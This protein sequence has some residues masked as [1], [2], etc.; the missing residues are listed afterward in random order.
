[1]NKNRRIQRNNTLMPPPP[2]LLEL[3][4]GTG[5]IGRAFRGLGWRV[6]SVDLDPLAGATIT[7]DISQLQAADLPRTPDVIWASPPCT[8]YSLAGCRSKRTTQELEESDQLVRKTLQLVEELGNPPCFI[9]NPFSG[10]LKRRGLLDHL[11]MQIV[12]YC[13]YSFPYRKR[14]AIWTN[15]EWEPAR[16]LCKHDCW[17]SIDGGRRHA[18]YAQQGPPGQRFTQQQLYRIPPDLC[19]E[20]ASFCDEAV[21]P[22]TQ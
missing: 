14:T 13:K 15:T 12:D 5:S 11:K 22:P 10:D 8:K 6:A 9:E 18:E 16:A 20:L 4:S 1:M 21:Q 17:A 3:F 2:V 7:A 19:G